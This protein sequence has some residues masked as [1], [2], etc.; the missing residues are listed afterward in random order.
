MRLRKRCDPAGQAPT[1]KDDVVSTTLT[2]PSSL[3]SSKRSRNATEELLGT[4]RC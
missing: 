1:W 2:G 4:W 3:Q